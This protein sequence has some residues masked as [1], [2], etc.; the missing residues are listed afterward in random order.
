ME[1]KKQSLEEWLAEE[2]ARL[3]EGFTYEPA[4]STSAESSGTAEEVLAGLG[5]GAGIAGGVVAAHPNP[6]TFEGSAASVIADALRAELPDEDTRV[7]V[8]KNG[9]STIVTVL[10][11]Q[12]ERGEFLPAL[13]VTLLEAGETLTVTV[14][15]RNEENVRRALS[16]MGEKALRRG[17]RLA[18]AR[19]RGLR[20]LL[21]TAGHVVEGLGDLAEDVQDLTLPRRV[22][23]VIDRVGEATEQAYLE[24]WRREQERVRRREA[25][26]RAWT[27]CEWCGHAYGEDEARLMTCPSC[28][29][30]RGNK[31]DFLPGT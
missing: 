7:R 22:W 20:G 29:A 8:D 14:G 5:L 13:A 9:P 25:A 31:P 19:R 16:S 4:P 1:D 27:H 28:G 30:P 26:L 3:D 12:G 23:R 10:Q 21:S 24:A 17:Q 11:S 15:E 6:V 2:Q 18:W